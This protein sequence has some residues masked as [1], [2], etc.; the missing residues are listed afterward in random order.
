MAP[1]FTNRNTKVAQLDMPLNS[2]VFQSALRFAMKCG[3]TQLKNESR[4]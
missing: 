4:V 2:L 3:E 1:S